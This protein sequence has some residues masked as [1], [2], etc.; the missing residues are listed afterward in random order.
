M[1]FLRRLQQQLRQV[2]LG[3]DMPRRILFSVLATAALAAIVLVGVWAAQPE[4]KVLYSSLA[5][6]DASAVI[7]K[8]DSLS[9]PYRLS[10]NGATISVPADRVS[11]LHVDLAGE[12]LPLKSGKGFEIFEEST[13]GTTPYLQHIQYQRAI[14]GE[15]EKTIRGLDQV[16]QARVFIVKPE[17]TPFVREQKPAT[18]SVIVWLKPGATMSRRTANGIVALVA[19]SVE[20]LTPENVVLLDQAGHALSDQRSSEAG[21]PSTQL[22][23]KREVESSLAAKAEEMLAQALGPGR[24]I[25]RVAADIN[26]KQTTE[27]RET[28]IPD[29]RVATSETINNS[30]S[31]GPAPGARGI[32]GATPNLGR[33]PAPATGGTSPESK[34]T[35]ESIK[36]EYAVSKTVQKIEGATG[37]LERMTVSA[38]V[39]LSRGEGAGGPSLTAKAAED[40]IKQAVGFK[41]DRDTIT[42][43]ESTPPPPPSTAEYED[44]QRW[45]S[46]VNIVRNASL[47]VA[48]FFALI[49]GV[50]YLRRLRPAG[51]PAPAPS[52]DDLERKQRLQS[53]T[54]AAKQDPEAIAR[55]LEAWLGP[56]EAP[57]RR[58]AA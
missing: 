34:E 5:P 17:P 14:Q 53:L 12:G 49:L 24:A 41:K 9:V 43:V 48:A 35:T 47:G 50:M 40:I 11:R 38:I 29:E 30:K 1:D 36:T 56:V 31:S 33:G 25:V 4:Y 58:A 6:E 52:A 44:L 57:P 21:I 22:E 45:Q 51:E 42:V 27:T 3:M 7:A 2:W 8:L 46:Y 39:D 55:G 28:Y 37:T 32:A 19:K 20:G 10:A 23:Y 18:A 15:L 54:E 26:F 13:I 16:T